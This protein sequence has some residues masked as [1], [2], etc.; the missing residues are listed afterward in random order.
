MKATWS[1]I[2]DCSSKE[3]EEVEE[4]ENLCLM[5]REDE[6]SSDGENEVIENFTLDELHDAFDDLHNEF[7]KLVVKCVALKKSSNELDMKLN[8]LRKEK[9]ALYEENLLLKKEVEK[10][11]NIAYNLTNRKENLEKL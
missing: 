1:D 11:F 8:A 10:F 9:M 5:E 2:K 4:M 6:H 3:D 7:Q